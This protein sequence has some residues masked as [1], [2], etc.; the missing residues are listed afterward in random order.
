MSK[1]DVRSGHLFLEEPVVE[2][3]MG[4]DP[5]L[6]LLILK[7]LG[8]YTNPLY[9]LKAREFAGMFNDLLTGP[10]YPALLVTYIR[11]GA[12]TSILLIDW[13][14]SNVPPPNGGGEFGAG[15]ASEIEILI[16]R[17]LEPVALRTPRGPQQKRL[18]YATSVEAWVLRGPGS[19]P[20]IGLFGNLGVPGELRAHLG[21]RRLM[22]RLGL[23]HNHDVRHT[24]V[25]GGSAMRAALHR[26]N[27]KRFRH[28]ETVY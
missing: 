23:I 28:A 13:S 3:L 1:I 20:S 16:A 26:T 11:E 14:G 21:Q 22:L 24:N 9:D 8:R 5:E 18:W 17:V 25:V 10:G 27:Y 19:A 6:A 15:L 2:F 7:D 4:L 12:V